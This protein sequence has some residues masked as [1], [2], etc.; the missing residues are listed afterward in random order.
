FQ[1]LYARR[2]V[3]QDSSRSR[4]LTSVPCTPAR[5][6]ASHASAIRRTP[7]SAAGSGSELPT[8]RAKRI[9]P[10]SFSSFFLA[11]SCVSATEENAQA[12]KVPSCDI[13][14]LDRR[15]N[16]MEHLLV[17]ERESLTWRVR[18]LTLMKMALM[19]K[20]ALTS[21]QKHSESTN[22]RGHAFH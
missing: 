22:A 12:L 15:R 3:A 21:D 7:R 19:K 5:H 2:L 13:A 14:S 17:K 18:H 9:D 6:A 1:A 10:L 20:P 8:A 16:L 11:R 4:A